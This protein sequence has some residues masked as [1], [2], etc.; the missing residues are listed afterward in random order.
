MFHGQEKKQMFNFQLSLFQV[1]KK[2]EKCREYKRVKVRI[3]NKNT[4]GIVDSTF[5]QED[6]SNSKNCQ[7]ILF[8]VKLV[9]KVRIF[10]IIPYLF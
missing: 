7:F 4:S 2:S 8:S 10:P 9:A 6:Y 5:S 1:R 3:C